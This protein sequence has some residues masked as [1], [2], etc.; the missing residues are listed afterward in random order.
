[1]C[2]SQR[3][4]ERNEGDFCDFL[5]HE[6]VCE[7]AHWIARSRRDFSGVES[8]KLGGRFAREIFWEA[9]HWIAR[10]SDFT[11]ILQRNAWVLGGKVLRSCALDSAQQALGLAQHP[12]QSIFLASSTT[13]AS[14][15][16]SPVPGPLPILE[17]CVD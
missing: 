13:E 17:A 3:K 1:M 7:A 12:S 2:S 11:W 9:A 15:G 4:L 5:E 14:H 16:V 6:G 10:I 8:G